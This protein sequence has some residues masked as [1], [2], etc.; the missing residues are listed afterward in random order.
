VAWT[1]YLP[2]LIEYVVLENG[3]DEVSQYRLTDVSCGHGIK[4]S[5]LTYL[6]TELSPS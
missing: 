1:L 4:H 2:E 5:V 3:S 6:L